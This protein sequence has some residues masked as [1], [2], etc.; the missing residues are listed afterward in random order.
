[1]QLSKLI[2][3]AKYATLK[4]RRMKIM[5]MKASLPKSLRKSDFAPKCFALSLGQMP[6]WWTLSLIVVER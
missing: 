4:V 1:M 5:S 2:L 6:S 3:L